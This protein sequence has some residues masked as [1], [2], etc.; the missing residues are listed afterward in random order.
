MH[1]P[2]YIGY[3]FITVG[4]DSSVDIAI[5][6]GL[7]GKGI[8]SR[9]GEGFSAPVQTGRGAHPAAHTMSTGIF[10]GSKAA[11]AWR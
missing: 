2:M 5:R 10:P 1:G 4:R 11:G 3:H 8:E 7:D 9:C 6:Y